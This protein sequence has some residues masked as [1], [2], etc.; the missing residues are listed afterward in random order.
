MKR[1]QA[2]G[3]DG[4]IGKPIDPQRFPKQIQQILAG[5]SVWEI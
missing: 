4:F 3:F 5:E 2:A 1:A